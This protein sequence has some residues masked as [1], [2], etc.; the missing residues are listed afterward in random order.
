[1]T[2]NTLK[3]HD[4]GPDH[5]MDALG[6]FYLSFL[7]IWTLIICA[8]LAALW[9]FRNNVAIRIRR[10]GLLASAIVIIHIYLCHVI[11]VYPLNG[12]FKCGLEFW[13]MSTILPFGIALFQGT[14]AGFG[15][16]FR[17][18]VHLS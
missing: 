8:G 4:F 12:S 2:A 14:F 15:Y 16:A 3:G 5:N 6:I 17:P 13:V 18:M 1:M 7:A 11:V 9:V 10:F